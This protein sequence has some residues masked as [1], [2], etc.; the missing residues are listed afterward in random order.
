MTCASVQAATSPTTFLRDLV[1]QDNALD[2]Q[3]ASL[4]LISTNSCMQLGSANAAVAAF[5]SL[6][7]AATAG[8]N[9]PLTLDAS[10]LA[11]LDSLSARGIK[12]K[13]S[14]PQGWWQVTCF[15]TGLAPKAVV[16][17]VMRKLTHLIYGVIKSGKLF[18]ANI[19]G[20]RLRFK[21]VSDFQLSKHGA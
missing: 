15:G 2:A 4:T 13:F 19:G 20:M 6:I 11:S 12:H 5:A 10:S 18:D 21:T 8:F 9:S 17:A 1:T 3:L 16:G 7:Q 14:D